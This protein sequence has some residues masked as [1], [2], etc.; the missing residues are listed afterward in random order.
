MSMGDG[1]LMRKSKI[2]GNTILIKVRNRSKN[3]LLTATFF[4]RPSL[5]S[6]PPFTTPRGLLAGLVCSM[7]V[8][9]DKQTERRRRSV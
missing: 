9:I 8:K 5:P 3:S 2:L 1:L 4:F 6:L 7:A